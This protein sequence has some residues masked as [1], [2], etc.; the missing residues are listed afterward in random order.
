MNVLAVGT[1]KPDYAELSARLWVQE[2]LFEVDA[3]AVFAEQEALSLAD[4]ERVSMAVA[5]G[6]P[7][8]WFG[9]VGRLS[10]TPT[11]QFLKFKPADLAKYQDL[12]SKADRTNYQPINCSFYDTFEIAIMHR[13]RVQLTYKGLNDEDHELS[14]KLRDTKTKLT[15]EYIQLEDSSWL[16]LDRIA[17]VDGVAAGASCSF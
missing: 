10:F 1:L 16:R 9:E 7:V 12:L 13:T 2:P 3:L 4:L 14:T 8:L 11:G 6:R 15:E 17:A 5:H